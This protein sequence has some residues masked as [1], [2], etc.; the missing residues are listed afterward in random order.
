MGKKIKNVDIPLEEL[1]LE[2][3]FEEFGEEAPEVKT[4]FVSHLRFLEKDIMPQVELFLLENPTGDEIQQKEL[5][6]ANDIESLNHYKEMIEQF[7]EKLDK[8]VRGYWKS[9]TSLGLSEGAKHKLQALIEN[10]LERKIF[11]PFDELKAVIEERLT[12][13]TERGFEKEEADTGIEKGIR[14]AGKRRQM[15]VDQFMRE[16][17]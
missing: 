7:H 9:G 1:G 13:F 14:E 17:N 6:T 16:N 12:D 10:K 4:K 2:I 5:N 3:N 8:W 15:P 11:A